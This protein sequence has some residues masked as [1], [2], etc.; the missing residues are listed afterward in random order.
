MKYLA[1]IEDTIREGLAKKTILGMFIVSTVAIIVAALLFQMDVI[2][3][4]LLAPAQGHVRTGNGAPTNM[5]GVTV[6]DMVWTGVAN[7]LLWVVV[8]V[9]AFVTTGF[10]TS[11]ME[12]GTIDLLLSKPVPR[13]LYI[14]GRYSGSVLIILAE[15]T[16]LILC[17]W[18]VAGISLGTWDADFLWSIPIITLAFAGI[19]AVITLFGILTRSSWFAL[20]LALALYLVT[21]IILPAGAWINRLLTGETDRGATYVIAKILNYAAPSLLSGSLTSTLVHRP[22]E[23]TPI[24]LTA[25][26]SLAYLALASWAFSKK[27]F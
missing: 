20:I 9:G 26:L 14:A 5:L 10:V 23:P 27:E 11:I 24:L 4:G 22:V 15:V 3:H 1:I 25:G 6:L 12:K 8:L 18:L 7:L 13:W 2:Q 19:Y 21:G 16:F 17:L